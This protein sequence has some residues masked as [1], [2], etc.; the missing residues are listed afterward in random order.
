MNKGKCTFC[1]ERFDNVFEVVDH[2]DDEF[3]PKFIVTGDY[4]LPM[5]DLL[6]DMYEG[7]NE[8]LKQLAEEL[9]SVLYIAEKR[10]QL[11]DIILQ[12]YPG[13]LTDWVYKIVSEDSWKLAGQGE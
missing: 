6:Y 2:L 1:G 13:N 12:S 9:F 4:K 7:G 10:P 8:E 11:F 3:N 5:S